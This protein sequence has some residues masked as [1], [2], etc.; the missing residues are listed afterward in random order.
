M[1]L[2]AHPSANTQHKQPTPKLKPW[3][4]APMPDKAAATSRVALAAAFAAALA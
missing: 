3:A 4:L 1:T 2:D